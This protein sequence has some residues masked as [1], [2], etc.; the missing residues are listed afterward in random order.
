VP[1]LLN[2]RTNVPE[3]CVG[4][5]QPPAPVQFEKVPTVQEVVLCGRLPTQF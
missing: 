2:V 4:E 3:V 5:A 1:A